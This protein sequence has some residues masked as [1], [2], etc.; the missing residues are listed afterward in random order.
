MWC[1]HLQGNKKPIPLSG[2]G[3]TPRQATLFQYLGNSPSLMTLFIITH[4]PF[5]LLGQV[6]QREDDLGKKNSKL[7]L[8]EPPNLMKQQSVSLPTVERS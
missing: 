2:K 1:I 8:D 5:K 6:V 7:C 4:H 3:L